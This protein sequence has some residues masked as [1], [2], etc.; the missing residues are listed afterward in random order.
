MNQTPPALTDS[1]ISNFQM[2]Q[3]AL[4]QLTAPLWFDLELSMA[5]FK[6]LLALARAAPAP[7][8]SVAETLGI[9]LPTASHLVDRLEQAGLVA[10]TTDVE[11]RRR[12]LASLTPV[13][14]ALVAQ[15]SASRHEHLRLWLTHMPTDELAAL[16]RGLQALAA[17]ANRDRNAAT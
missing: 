13:G 8:S 16:A 5:Q 12:T 10:R 1:A 15:L 9:S 17:I 2:I 6:A 14:Q 11:D 7:I 4:Q 3:Q